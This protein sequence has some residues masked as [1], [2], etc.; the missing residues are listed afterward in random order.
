MIVARFREASSY[1]DSLICPLVVKELSKHA[2]CSFVLEVRLG[3]GDERD[4][5]KNQI[6][7]L[8]DVQEKDALIQSWLDSDAI[9]VLCR[10]G[11]P[12]YYANLRPLHLGVTVEG[13][14]RLD[15][16]RKLYVHSM[17]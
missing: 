9:G 17:L 7:T 12:I 16:A 11:V 5:M 4:E 13:A 8:R 10:N 3:R 2:L 1:S 14:T 15:V 6:T